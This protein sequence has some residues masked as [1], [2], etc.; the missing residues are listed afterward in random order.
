[1]VEI[2]GEYN[3]AKVFTNTADAATLKQ[4]E[5][6]CSQKAFADSTIRIMPDCHAGKGAT[7]GTTMTIKDKV[8]PGGVGVDIN[9]GM[10]VTE[11]EDRKIELQRLDKCIH[12]CV[13]HG[14]GVNKK[15]HRWADRIDLSKLRCKD[16]IKWANQHLAIGSLGSGNHF[17]SIEQ[18]EDEVK[19]LI[20]HT[21][22]RNLGL[23]VANYYQQAAY[24][25]L[26]GSDSFHEARAKAEKQAIVATLA[27][28]GRDSEISVT[29][30]NYKYDPGISRELLDIPFELCYVEGQLFEDYI[31]DMNIAQEFATLNRLAIADT[32]QCGM[33]WKVKDQWETRHNYIDLDTMILR[34][35]AISAQKGEIGIIPMNMRDGSLIVQGK[36]NPDW[37][38]S[39][40]HGAGRVMSRTEAKNSIPMKDFKDSM[41]G[42]F[43][44]SVNANTV[45]EAPQAYKPMNEIINNIQDTCTIIKHLH[46]IYNFKAS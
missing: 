14:S 40:P 9:C 29:L 41:E 17:I 19:Y 38:F 43:T 21:G 39:A 30:K 6:L 8:I 13:P 24:D 27:E 33:R 12:K 15:P 4:I 32:I 25:A 3:T 20:I 45:D 34:K 46:P 37:N 5:T 26:H 18:D 1:M 42:I 11:I 36:G 7:I 23:Q 10:L 28:E 16:H 35:G 31:H 22:S 2:K 44:T